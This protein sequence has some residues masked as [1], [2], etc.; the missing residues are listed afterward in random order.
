MTD[1]FGSEQEREWTS[2]YFRIRE[3]LRTFGDGTDYVIV[4]SNSGAYRHRIETEKLDL[5]RPPVIAALQK[6]LCTWQNWEIT[7]VLG[8][9]GGVV[10][11]DDEIIDGLHRD[12][13]PLEF[14]AMTYEGSRPLGSRFGDIMYSGMSVSLGPGPFAIRLPEDGSIGLP[15]SSVLKNTKEE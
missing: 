1:D 6:L 3:V 8:D 4:D 12:A 7:V 13:L 10:V 14:Q 5:V 15:D 2:L 9:S 11:R